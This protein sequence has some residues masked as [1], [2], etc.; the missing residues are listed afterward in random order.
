MNP[1]RIT[2]HFTSAPSLE[3]LQALTQQ[4]LDAGAQSL[5]LLA[6]DGNGC[7]PAVFDPWLQSLQVPVAG[8]VFT[9]L[10]HDQQHHEKGYLVLGWPEAVL[11][12]HVAGLSDPEVDF[13][14]SVSAALGDTL[15]STS[16]MVWVDGLSSRIAA[17]LDGLYDVMG[18]DVAYFG[19][20]AGSLS[21][22]QKPSLFSNQGMLQDH[23]QLV[24]MTQPVSLG[25][26]HGWQPFSG[27]FVVTQSRGNV[28]QSLD[29]QPAFQVYQNQVQ[30]D[31]G[32]VFRGDNFFDIA[33]GYPFGMEKAD[34]SLVV[35]DPISTDGN[36][37]ICVGEVPVNSVVYLLKGQA[38]QLIAAASQ[39]ASRVRAGA[40]PVFMV[41][42]ISRVLF[43]QGRFDE[44]LQAV[45]ATV[46]GRPVVGALT[47][48][49]VANGG[50]YCL[51]FYNKTVVLAGLTQ[52]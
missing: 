43:L 33:K 10:I 11:V 20:G 40:G 23:A 21:F 49:E 5:I 34:H 44:E 45:Q 27:P 30:A 6:A 26:D 9:Q 36:A 25:V 31:S 1:D 38:D 4:A 48:G 29:F 39:G 22:V 14:D 15:E 32:Q 28:V 19:G 17:F 52:D 16:L 50:D 46:G 7:D 2:I 51:E 12:R 18:A 24:C 37:L 3:D 47:L 13:T 8:G 41:D 35:R 42:C